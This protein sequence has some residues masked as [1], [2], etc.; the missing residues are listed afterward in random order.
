MSLKDPHLAQLVLEELA[1]RRANVLQLQIAGQPMP[2]AQHW[3][4][5]AEQFQTVA[6]TMPQTPVESDAVGVRAW[7]IE[8]A[9][10]A[11][12]QGMAHAAAGAGK[13]WRRR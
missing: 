1:R 3:N 4:L 8:D 2:A 11:L 5:A 10:D 7:S 13:H 6:L 9:L 12:L